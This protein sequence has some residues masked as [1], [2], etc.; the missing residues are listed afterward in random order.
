MESFTY[1]EI[2]TMASGLAAELRA[3]GIGKGDRVML[4]GVNSAEWAAAFFGC[5]I[6]GVVVVPMDDGAAAD[7]DRPRGGLIQIRATPMLEL[8]ASMGELA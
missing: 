5:V 6:S 8:R 1:S 3:R 4:W 7:L 2:L